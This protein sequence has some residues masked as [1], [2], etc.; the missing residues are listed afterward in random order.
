MLVIPQASLECVF[1]LSNSLLKRLL[2]ISCS[3][4]CLTSFLVVFLILM[5]ERRQER[6][7]TEELLEIPLSCSLLLLRLK[8]WNLPNWVRCFFLFPT[9]LNLD[10]HNLMKLLEMMMIKNHLKI[11]LTNLLAVCVGRCYPISGHCLT[12]VKCV[13]TQT[14]GGEWRTEKEQLSL[15]Y[16]LVRLILP[17]WQVGKLKILVVIDLGQFF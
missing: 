13:H 1:T 10:I 14:L 15:D 5:V 9:S 16:L 3:F 12:E 11:C 7:S 2:P 17:A 8:Q 4:C 6:L